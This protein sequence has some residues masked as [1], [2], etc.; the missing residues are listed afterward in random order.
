MITLLTFPAGL[1]EPSLSPFCT[2]VIHLLNMSGQEWQRKDVANPSRMPHGKLPVIQ[3]DG[4]TIADS[5]LIQAA[6]ERAGTDFYAGVGP[7]ERAQG[8]AILRMIE[9]IPCRALI[10]DRWVP[11]HAWDI[12]RE[13]FFAKMPAVMRKHVSNVIRKSVRRGLERH[14]IALCTEAERLALVDRDLAAL[15]EFLGDRPF[16]LGDAVTAADAG[17]SAVL[18]AIRNLPVE[19]PLRHRIRS[20]KRITLYLDRC[21]DAFRSSYV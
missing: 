5:H 15:S 21:T 19:T 16:V 17:C 18:G 4:Q 14:G 8:Q 12:C 6:L 13:V 9:D 7:L 2:K 3:W 20:D 10:Y 11:D 1:H